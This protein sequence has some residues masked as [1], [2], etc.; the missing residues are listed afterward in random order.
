L[1][2][3]LGNGSVGFIYV[4]YIVIPVCATQSKVAL[5]FRSA[6]WSFYIFAAHAASGRETDNHPRR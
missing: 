1:A 4:A 5:T 3:V 6:S 2:D